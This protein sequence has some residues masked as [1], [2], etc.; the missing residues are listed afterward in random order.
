MGWVT[1]IRR[2]HLL[3]AG[4]DL[5]WR[6]RRSDRPATKIRPFRRKEQ[7]LTPPPL[8]AHK[9]MHAQTQTQSQKEQSVRVHACSYGLS[10]QIELTRLYMQRTIGEE[11]NGKWREGRGG[12]WEASGRQ[13]HCLKDGT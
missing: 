3:G 7:R 4:I 11:E 12:D 5:A 10:V 2:C 9:Y 6:E 13:K 8:F 1:L